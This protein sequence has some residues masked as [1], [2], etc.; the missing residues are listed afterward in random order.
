MANAKIV[1]VGAGELK[2]VTE[3]YNEVFSPR[4]EE[5]FFKRRFQGRHN[6]SMMVAMVDDRPVGFTVGFELMPSTYYSWLCG[7]VADF[8]RTGIATQLIQ[9]QQAWAQDHH[10]SIIRFECQNQHRPMLHVAITEGYDLIGV[11]WDTA[12]GENVVIFERDLR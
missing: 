11:R 9:A 4:Q 12:T 2:L 3:L 7:V 6:V 5:E 8:R 10:Y 1:P